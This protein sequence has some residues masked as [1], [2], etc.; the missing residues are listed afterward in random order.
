MT[1][2]LNDYEAIYNFL[3]NHV[4]PEGFSKVQKRALRRKA[5]DNYKVDRGQLFYKKSGTQ[6]W[7]QVPRINRERRRILETCHGLP[8]GKTPWLTSHSIV[9]IM[10]KNLC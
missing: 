2:I 9:I 1:T 4:Y 3:F 5:S 7:K 10:D 8:E 6:N